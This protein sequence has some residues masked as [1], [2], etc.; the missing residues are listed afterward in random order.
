MP[1][2]TTG[3]MIE[4]SRKAKLTPT[5]RASMLVATARKVRTRRSRRFATPHA[6]FGR[7]RLVDHLSAYQRQKSEGD[8]V[9][10]TD[11]EVAEL[12][13]AEPADHR[14]E[15]L[16]GAEEESSSE[17]ALEP[18]VSSRRPA[19]HRDRKGVHGKA[20]GDQKG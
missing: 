11:D 13:P 4:T 2:T 1:I 10:V 5:A 18:V 12:K 19:G 20:E 6:S 9:I 7:H 17:G 16:K 15:G 8:P 14:H 3:T